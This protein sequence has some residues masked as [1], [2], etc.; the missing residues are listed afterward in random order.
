LFRPKNAILTKLIHFFWG[1]PLLIHFFLGTSGSAKATDGA[2]SSLL[3]HLIHFFYGYL[4][5]RR[6]KGRVGEYIGKQVEQVDQW[7][8]HTI[9][10][11]LE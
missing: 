3:I 6:L 7:I 2:A 9:C 1:D 8:S 4:Y 11:V 10:K 5:W